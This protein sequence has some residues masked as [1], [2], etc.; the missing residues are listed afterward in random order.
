MSE[1]VLALRK[2]LSRDE[3]LMQFPVEIRSFL[4]S[5]WDAWNER[6]ATEPKRPYIQHSW[7][8]EERQVLLDGMG[9]TDAELAE[10]L[11]LPVEQI[12]F[13]RF[14]LRKA[15]TNNAREWLEI[16]N[17]AIRALGPRFPLTI[18]RKVF[19]ADPQTLL[20]QMKSLGV[21]VY[22]TPSRRIEPRYPAELL[23][24]E[25]QV[26]TFATPSSGTTRLLMTMQFQ[27]TT[28]RVYRTP[29]Q[30]Y[31]ELCELAGV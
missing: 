2:G 9:R 19:K 18:L 29:D 25:H 15:E 12:A 7:T 17:E 4:P 24:F 26:R 28:M 21:T 13:K 30:M 23:A 20:K 5:I 22:V 10:Q 27:S 1:S 11:A 14:Q 31:E 6:K 3:R 16:E 8:A